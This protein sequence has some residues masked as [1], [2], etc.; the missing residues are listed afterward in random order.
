MAIWRTVGG[1]WLFVANVM[2]Q[3]R[4]MGRDGRPIWM[5]GGANTA[6]YIMIYLPARTDVRALED[7]F[8]LPP[9]KIEIPPGSGSF[10]LVDAVGDQARAFPNEFRVV[11]ASKDHNGP[12]AR[13]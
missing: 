8:P 10:W 9:D 7:Q 3:M 5:T 13:P 4:F 1:P 12:A 11:M 6:D 2:G